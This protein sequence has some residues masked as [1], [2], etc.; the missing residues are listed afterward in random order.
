MAS[1]NPNS[2]PLYPQIIDSHPDLNTPFLSSNPTSNSSLYPKIDPS[3]N[4]NPDPNP[5]SSSSS[6]L[7]PTVDVSD[8]AENLF[9]SEEDHPQMEPPVEEVLLKVP[10]AVLH[11]IDRQ[12][13]VDL[14]S[15]EFSIVRIKQGENTVAVLARLGEAVQWPLTPDVASVK[16]DLSHYFFSIHVPHTHGDDEEEKSEA[17]TLLNYGLTFAAK[18]QEKLLKE[19]DQI[20]GTYSS[21]SVQKVE[22]K[23]KEKSEVLD[24][25]FTR[26]I[27]P[28]EAAGPK[29]EIIEEKS[30]AFW[31]TLAPNVEDYSGAIPKAI[32][33]STGQVIKGII[34][35]GDVTT[36]RLKWGEDFLKRKVGPSSKQ[37]EVSRDALKRMKRV[38]KVTKMSETVANGILS[39]VLKVTGFF[40]SSVVNSKAG[41]KFFSLLPGEIALASL[42]AFG[43]ICDAVEVAG[44][45]V[46]QTSSTVTTGFVSHRYGDQAGEMTHEGLHAAGHAFGTAWAVFKLRKALNPKNAVKPSSV[47]KNALKAAASEVKNGKAKK[48]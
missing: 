22:A 29:K 10:G 28:E 25:S 40:T 48:K 7:Y 27:T 4:T 32:A 14:G 15:G 41:K 34:W 8:L 30:A 5:T 18:G 9:A 38:K 43:K 12:R 45:N 1:Q 11:L 44:K 36:D 33:M 13:S 24:T 2:K 17:E 21:F 16:V 26:S 47:A 42:D 3:S 23:G 6:N 37:T 31:T 39:G 35:C 46:L 19:L 20:L